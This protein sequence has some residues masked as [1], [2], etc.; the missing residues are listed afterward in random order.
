MAVMTTILLLCSFLFTSFSPSKSGSVEHFDSYSDQVESFEQCPL[1]TTFSGP[2]CEPRSQIVKLPLPLN[3][4]EVAE[5]LPAFAEVQRCS[6]NCHQEND[7]HKCVPV[8]ESK[9]MKITEVRRKP[10]HGVCK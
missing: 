4:P 1:K 9:T 10:F 6:G 3:F 5:V 2:Q 8:D 7:F